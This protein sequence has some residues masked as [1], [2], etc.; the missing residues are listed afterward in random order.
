MRPERKFV[1]ETNARG[2]KI[3][4]QPSA[5]QK[6]VGYLPPAHN[7]QPVDFLALPPI[8]HPITPFLLITQLYNDIA[9][10]RVLSSF[11]TNR[12]LLLKLSFFTNE[13]FIPS[14]LCN[15]KSSDAGGRLSK[16][17]FQLDKIRST[18][19]RCFS[20]ICIIHSPVHVQKNCTSSHR[21]IIVAHCKIKANSD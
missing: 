9:S 1:Q 20:L 18:S 11:A 15:F 17:L 16:Y 14:H 19:A 13:V 10:R 21:Q 8:E 5:N 6:E 3:P 2:R 4:S 7:A 12:N